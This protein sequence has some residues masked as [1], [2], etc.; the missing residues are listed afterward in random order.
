MTA[1]GS[2]VTLRGVVPNADVKHLAVGVARNTVGVEK[3]EDELAIP[4]E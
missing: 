4:A 3:V 1:E 2:V